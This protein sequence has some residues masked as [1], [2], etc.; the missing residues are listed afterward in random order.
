MAFDPEDCLPVA[1]NIFDALIRSDTT[2]VVPRANW[3]P[4]VFK[5]EAEGNTV[6]QVWSWVPQEGQVALEVIREC[7]TFWK[8]DRWY[9]SETTDGRVWITRAPDKNIEGGHH[10]GRLPPWP[11]R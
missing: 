5:M 4:H 1:R 3:P 6:R 10:S 11:L 2:Q 8:R 9:L 7:S